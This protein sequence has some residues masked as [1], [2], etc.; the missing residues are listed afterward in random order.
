[1]HEKRTLN[2]PQFIFLFFLTNPWTNLNM[3]FQSVYT[4]L[5]TDGKFA[6]VI[7]ARIL[8]II[9]SDLSGGN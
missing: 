4:L 9:V 7:I 5:Y 6:F 8:H 3:L 2:A 1:M